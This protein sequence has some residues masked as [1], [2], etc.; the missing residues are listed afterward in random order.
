MFDFFGGVAH[1][2]IDVGA[3]FVGFD[4]GGVTY[5]SCGAE[6]EDGLV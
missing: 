6:D 1:C 5:G 4:G 3:S 2:E